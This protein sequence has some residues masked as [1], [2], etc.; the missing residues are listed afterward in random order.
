[1][2]VIKIITETVGA[3]LVFLG[4]CAIVGAGA[5]V[6]VAAYLDAYELINGIP[7]AI[8]GLV[9]MGG[10]LIMYPAALL[11]RVPLKPEPDVVSLKRK[12]NDATARW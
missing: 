6:C 10:I 5:F 7:L 9:A 8:P 4:I 12:N 2:D 3:C 11:L 1:M